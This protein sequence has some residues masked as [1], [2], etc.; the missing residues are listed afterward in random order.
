MHTRPRN[1]S[2]AERARRR[3]AAGMKCYNKHKEAYME[4]QKQARAKVATA[5]AAAKALTSL[6]PKNIHLSTLQSQSGSLA[7]IAT[8]F[9]TDVSIDSWINIKDKITTE[10][11]AQF[12][13]YF[14]PPESW[15]NIPLRNPKRRRS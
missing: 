7:L 15:P 1:L 9:T 4:H 2:D 12:I 3:K 10:T 13:T 6:R 11:F 8:I 5:L 14:Y